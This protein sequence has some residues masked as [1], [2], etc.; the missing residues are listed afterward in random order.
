[1]PDIAHAA[2]FVNIVTSVFHFASLRYSYWHTV[3]KCERIVLFV[4]IPN[5]NFQLSHRVYCIGGAAAETIKRESDAEWHDSH[6][7]SAATT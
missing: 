2:V 5:V 4:T 1:L 6:S 3:S 7:L